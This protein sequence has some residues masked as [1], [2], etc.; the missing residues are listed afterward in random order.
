VGGWVYSPQIFL[1]GHFLLLFFCRPLVD[2]FTKH[3]HVLNNLFQTKSDGFCY[4]EWI[5]CVVRHLLKF[6]F[7]RKRKKEKE[8]YLVG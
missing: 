1:G 4:D 8:K 6:F 2:L 7:C 3:E 5:L